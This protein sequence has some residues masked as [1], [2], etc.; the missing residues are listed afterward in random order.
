MKT[1][2]LFLATVCLLSGCAS[3]NVYWGPALIGYG[4][5]SA[6]TFASGASR[7]GAEYDTARKKHKHSHDQATT[8]DGSEVEIEEIKV[9]SSSKIGTP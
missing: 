8:D 4:S 2:I 3:S 1:R 9:S 5:G 6:E 7:N